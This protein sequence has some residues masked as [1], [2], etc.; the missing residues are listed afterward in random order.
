M[1]EAYRQKMTA[2][3]GYVWFLPTWFVEDW[4]DTDRYNALGTKEK[5]PCNT[6][7][8]IQVSQPIFLLPDFLIA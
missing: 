8:M 7:Q 3:E 2:E 5:I 4:Y 1:C 6:S